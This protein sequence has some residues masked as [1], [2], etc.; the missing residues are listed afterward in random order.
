M[1]QSTEERSNRPCRRLIAAPGAAGLGLITGP[2]GHLAGQSVIVGVNVVALVALVYY[3]H[4]SG[5]A[6]APRA[7]P[8]PFR[9][10]APSGC[11]W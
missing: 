9:A 10:R 8:S 4:S 1:Y 2:A 6:A 3:L 11:G 5:R 7:T